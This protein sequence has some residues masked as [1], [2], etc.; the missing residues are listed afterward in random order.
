M[1][2]DYRNKPILLS[3]IILLFLVGYSFVDEFYLGKL[4]VKR[5]DFFADIRKDTTLEY[6]KKLFE[7]NKQVTFK[8]SNQIAP[9]VD[10]F[11]VYKNNYSFVYLHN[12][13]TAL[14]NEEHTTKPIHI[15]YFGDSEIEGDLITGDL[16]LLLQ[17]KFGGK[18]VGYL[19]FA[20]V[21]ANFRNQVAFDFED[22][23]INTYALNKNTKNY[24]YG[25][26]GMVFEPKNEFIVKYKQI[27]KNASYDIIRVFYKIKD[28]NSNPYFY[29]NKQQIEIVAKDNNLSQY[30]TKAPSSTNS[31]EIKLMPNTLR[32]YGISLESLNGIYVD[33]F[34]LRGYSGMTLTKIPLENL[35]MFDKFL[36]YRLVVLQYGMNVLNDNTKDYS[37]YKA[38]MKDVIEHFKKAFPKAD[39]LVIS[40]GDKGKKVGDRYITD[41]NIFNLIKAQKELAEETNASFINLFDVMGGVNTMVKWVNKGLASP[42][43]VHLSRGG[44]KII[45]K[46][47]FDIISNYEKSIN[48]L[49]QN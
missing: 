1:E 13:W 38:N 27:S 32:F 31:L 45:A 14:K 22:D 5:I 7:L 10:S 23:N 47:I 49:V 15:A 21:D 6:E 4:K 41:A 35:R 30:I 2:K 36:N 11:N 46:K 29:I 16:R 48:N 19:P 28:T 26:S 20:S 33:N 12:F 18:G 42:D 17:E 3:I 24:D 43:Y 44:G 8:V 25:I 39:I 34:S 37:F 9:A 40:I